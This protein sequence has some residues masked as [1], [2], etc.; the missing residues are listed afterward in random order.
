MR[1]SDAFVLTLPPGSIQLYLPHASYS[2]YR[3]PVWLLITLK[4]DSRHSSVPKPT[5]T[6][7]MCLNLSFTKTLCKFRNLHRS[8]KMKTKEKE[9]EMHYVAKSAWTTTQ[10]IEFQCF[11][12]NT[13]RHLKQLCT[14]V[15]TILGRSFLFQ[16]DY[17]LVH[18]ANS[19][20]TCPCPDLHD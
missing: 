16:H 15:A 18:K 17:A 4:L 6:T 10:S 8:K 13:Q 2:H 5:F 3:K 19:I 7:V 11:F 12:W 1:K 9:R 14:R 20:K